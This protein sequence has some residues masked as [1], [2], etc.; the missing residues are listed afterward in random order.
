MKF[1]MFPLFSLQ[2]TVSDRECC[3]VMC[4][5]SGHEGV[6]G[7]RGPP[8]SKVTGTHTFHFK[9]NGKNVWGKVSEAIRRL[10][11]ERADAGRVLSQCQVLTD[12]EGDRK[13]LFILKADR[14]ESSRSRATSA[15][16]F[17]TVKVSEQQCRNT[18][19]WVNI[20]HSKSW[21]QKCGLLQV[22]VQIHLYSH[23]S[24]AV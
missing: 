3:N 23:E 22:K 21:R 4:K 2:D 11:W 6:R 14:N 13:R 7:L 5:C 17:T 9:H 20:L 18:L 19:L 1:L 16:L 12:T 15:L 24:F 8:G 10:S